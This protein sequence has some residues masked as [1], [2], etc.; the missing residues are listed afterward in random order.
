MGKDKVHINI[1]VIGHVDSGKSTT[2][3]HLI[4]KLGGIDIR[5]IERFEKEATE[6][7]SDHSSMLGTTKYYYTVIDAP[8]H[9]NFIK[10]MINGTS[11]ADC[12]VL[13]I[14][15][16]TGGFAAGI[17][18][19]GQTREHALLAFTLG[20]KQMICRCNKMF[21]LAV[22]NAFY[23]SFGHMDA[24]TPKHSK[25]RY[26]EIVKE[27]SSYLKK[28]D[29]VPFVPISAFEGDNI[30][31]RFTNLDQY[32]GPT[33]LEALDMI[34]EPKR[35][36]DKPLRL[37]LRDVYK[38]GGIGTVRVGR[39]ETGIIKPGMVVTFGPTGLTTESLVLSYYREEMRTEQ[40]KGRGA[41]NRTE[42]GK[43][44]G[45]WGR[46][47]SCN[48]EMKRDFTLYIDDAHS[49]NCLVPSKRLVPPKF[50]CQN[51][52]NLSQG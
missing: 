24:T 50:L 42:Q 3:G 46:I 28:V 16:T 11:Q 23:T 14:D 47:R 45:S 41:C 51:N 5:V 15:S 8:G 39:V 29:K 48:S 38:I 31:E 10:N 36:S 6:M 21:F 49:R 1:V 18:K 19:D 43:I 9:R 2:T 33:L 13:I 27:V 40:A 52:S 32:K 25:A 20:V 4:Y 37:P 30:I 7:T 12:A 34:Q 26:D 22:I 17:S 35:P 44:K